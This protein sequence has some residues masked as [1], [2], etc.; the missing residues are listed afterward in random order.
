MAKKEVGHPW[1]RK[2]SAAAA[3]LRTMDVSDQ[4]ASY[5]IQGIRDMRSDVFMNK[6]V[7][8]VARRNS[9]PS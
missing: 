9:R 2:A 3:N 4:F 5:M 7:P 1:L 8:Q 6:W